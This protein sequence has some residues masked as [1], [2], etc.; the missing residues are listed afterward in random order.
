MSEYIITVTVD[1]NDGDFLTRDEEISEE[2]LKFI[3]P[4]IEEIRNYK[5]YYN[6]PLY[7]GEYYNYISSKYRGATPE[8]IYP[9]IS[10]DVFEEFNNYLPFWEYGFHTIKSIYIQPVSSRTRLL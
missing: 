7:Y 10:E 5:G 6:Y 9:D 3:H 2:K 4:L 1:C 8:E